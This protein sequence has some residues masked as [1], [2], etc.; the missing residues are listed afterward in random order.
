MEKLA[1]VS[2]DESGKLLTATHPSANARSA[3]LARAV[4]LDIEKSAVPSPAAS[5]LQK[6]FKN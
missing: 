3:L 2:K 1:A 4:N 5:R 6:Q